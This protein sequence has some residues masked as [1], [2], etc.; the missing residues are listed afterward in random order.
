MRQFWVLWTFY[1]TYAASPCC[2]AAENIV[3][4]IHLAS[5]YDPYTKNKH[6]RQMRFI[7]FEEGGTLVWDGAAP[8]LEDSPGN[9]VTV[10][11]IQG[12]QTLLTEENDD[13]MWLEETHVCCDTDYHLPDHLVPFGR[14][15]K[16]VI[17]VGNEDAPDA[18]YLSPYTEIMVDQELFRFA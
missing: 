17:L 8:K 6:G 15:V 9:V 3:K 13:L 10:G 14:R 1:T 2:V 5:P 18:I 4:A 16:S 12:R 7:V 11:T